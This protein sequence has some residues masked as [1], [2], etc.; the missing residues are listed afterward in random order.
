[1]STTDSR[2]AIS[3]LFAGIQGVFKKYDRVA[4]KRAWDA[5]ISSRGKEQISKI[6]NSPSYQLTGLAKL[7]SFKEWLEQNP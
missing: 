3:A 2:D 4:R 7:A 1:M 6:M 5:V